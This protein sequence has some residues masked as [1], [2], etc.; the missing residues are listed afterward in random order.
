MI[1]I[2]S[3]IFSGVTDTVF[4]FSRGIFNTVSDG[5][6]TIINRGTEQP[7]NGRNKMN[8]SYSSNK[9][10]KMSSKTARGS[11][12]NNNNNAGLFGFLSVFNSNR[13]KNNIRGRHINPWR[14]F[15]QF[16]SPSSSKK[17]EKKSN[18]WL[19]A[20]NFQTQNVGNRIALE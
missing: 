11:S 14:P 10:N 18:S 17:V 16:L 13:H 15:W 6:G 8:K 7:K 1:S 3:S 12:R 5:F 20:L 19:Q 2:S 4:A 9:Q